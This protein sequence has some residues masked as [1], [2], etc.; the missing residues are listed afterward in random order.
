MFAP[1]VAISLFAVAVGVAASLTFIV[2][3][4]QQVWQVLGFVT[5]GLG[6]LTLLLMF[7]VM[8]SDPGI[9]SRRHQL[10]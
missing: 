7:C 1:V 2:Y 6:A 10:D 9:Q 3:T 4:Q 8:C 5:T